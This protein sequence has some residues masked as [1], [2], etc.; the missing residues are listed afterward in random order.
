M[1]G[2]TNEESYIMKTYTISTWVPVCIKT[3]VQ[4]KSHADALKKVQDDTGDCNTE[5]A[6]DLDWPVDRQCLNEAIYMPQHYPEFKVWDEE[7]GD[8]VLEG[9]EKIEMPAEL[10]EAPALSVKEIAYHNICKGFHELFGEEVNSDPM[11]N[12]LRDIEYAA[13]ELGIHGDFNEAYLDHAR[14]RHAGIRGRVLDDSE[15]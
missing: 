3:T 15:D 5:G 9:S 2:N 10:S 7:I 13:H 8:R 12:I 1:R 11:Q 6:W 14:G 4:A